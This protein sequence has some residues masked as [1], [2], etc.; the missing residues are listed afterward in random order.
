MGGNKTNKIFGE[1]MEGLILYKIVVCLT[2]EEGHLYSTLRK[3]ESG[4][5][6]ASALC[7]SE[8]CPC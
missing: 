8:T 7:V 2:K 6:D 3:Q 5:S 1:M 4:M